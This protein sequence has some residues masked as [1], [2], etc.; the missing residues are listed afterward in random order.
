[1]V[2]GH[3]V[4]FGAY[5]FWLP[6]DPRG[7]WSDFVGAWDLFRYGKA[8]KTSET[9][10]LARRQ[11]DPR[12]RQAAKN[13]LKRPA[14]KFNMEQIESVAAG[15]AEYAARAKLSMFACAILPDHVHLV[16]GRHRLKAEKLVIQLKAA[17]TRQLMWDGIHPF[18][19][20]AG[21]KRPPKCFARG[22]W[23]VF[24]DSEEGF[25]RSI[26]YVERNPSKEGMPAQ[27]WDF[28]TPYRK[29]LASPF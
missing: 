25:E 11:H 4:I 23:D 3:H 22:Q 15:I 12:L 9:R 26:S 2:L 10:S 27:E 16:L 28:V 17:A 21:G 7:S 20:L 8:T 29:P 14:V 5:G 13:A 18:A 19:N 1:M 24:L 6:N